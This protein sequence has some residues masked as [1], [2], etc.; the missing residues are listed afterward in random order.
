MSPA[1]KKT[2]KKTTKKVL[3]KVDVV[4]AADLGGTNLR[5]ALISA[6]GRLISRVE[7]SSADGQSPAGMI[8]L[9]GSAARGLVAD[10]GLQHMPR[11]GIGVAGGIDAARG[12]VTQSP[13]FPKWKNFALGPRLE[14]A[15][16]TKVLLANDVD[17]A[18]LGERWLG[19][20]KG[21]QTVVAYWLGTGV[22]GA[23]VL[24]GK[25]WNGPSGMAGE[26]GHMLVD[27]AGERCNCGARGCLET[28][29]SATGIERAARKAA[30]AGKPIKLDGKTARTAREVFEAAVAGDAQAR[31]IWKRAG[32]ALGESI[33]GLV[34]AL[35]IDRVVIGGKVAGAGRFFLPELRRAAKAR[36]FR[37]PGSRLHLELAELG[38]DA[39]LLGAASLAL[40]K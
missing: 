19:A 16:G 30:R 4:L 36:A 12:I 32:W 39:G 5:C 13:Q 3:S 28:I 26:L 33:G 38:D 18:L 21:A 15:L 24:D 34:N 2:R 25:L 40:G 23:L 1:I 22:G 17:A 8:A 7:V 29:S 14:E 9:F 6:R 20:A 11:I 31:A 10:A 27:P 37:Y 35:S